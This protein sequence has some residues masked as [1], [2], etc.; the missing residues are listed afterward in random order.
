M[1]FGNRVYPIEH[2]A[3]FPPSH[4]QMAPPAY[5]SSFVQFVTALGLHFAT[6]I[7]SKTS[8]LFINHQHHKVVSAD[9][10]AEISVH[11]QN[12]HK[13]K[14]CLERNVCPSSRLGGKFHPP[15]GV[16]P[17]NA[18]QHYTPK[19]QHRRTII[20]FK[21]SATLIMDMCAIM[22]AFPPPLVPRC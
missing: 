3:P 8:S 17:S 10:S 1:L 21:E 7:Q 15:I 14:P 6:H 2:H 19:S 13:I 16:P 12:R 11:L 9:F 18:R 22:F 4:Q 20:D 5:C